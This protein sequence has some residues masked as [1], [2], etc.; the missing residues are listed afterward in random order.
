MSNVKTLAKGDILFKEGDKCQSLILIQSGAVQLFIARPKKNIE[1]AIL[2]AGQVLGEQAFASSAY[3][4]SAVAT[5]ETKYIEVP[6]DTYRQMLDGSHQVL[7]HVVKSLGDRLKAATTEIRTY[8]AEKDPAPCPEDQVA[9]VFGTI[10]HTLNH[11]G[12]RDAKTQTVSIDWPL[13]RQYSQRVFGESLKRLE[14]AC[15]IL[16][17]IKIA[18]YEMGKAI[19]NPDGPDE[20]QKFHVQDLAAVEAFFEF[21]QYHYFKGG[22]SDLLKSDELATNLLQA[23]LKLSSN[24]APDRLGVVSLEYAAVVEFMKTE[25]NINLNNDH[26]NRLTLKGLLSK[27]QANT[28]GVLRFS[29][30]LK[31]Y[32]STAKIWR[33]L[34]EIEKWNE[35]G[36]VDPLEVED[37]KAKRK[38]TGPSCPSCGT[39][40]PAEAKFCPE[41]GAKLTGE[42][43]A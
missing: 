19:D 6:G 3:A 1:I 18:T 10:F 29:F 24:V 7:K 33:I 43:A 5:A 25:L 21:F 14:Q 31:E 4:F 39:G 13:F 11:K 12:V 42:K 35:K 30:D 37:N 40:I 16:V 20:I 22:R 27:R 36:F 26:L 8:R 23:I 32:Q 15:N 9:K 28:E 34:R 17:K 41:C 38:A 2:G